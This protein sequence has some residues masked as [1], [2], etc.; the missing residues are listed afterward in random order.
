MASAEPG[1]HLTGEALELAREPRAGAVGLLLP[2]VHG[3]HA[4]GATGVGAVGDAVAPADV[5]AEVDQRVPARVGEASVREV[6]A[7]I[8]PH[9]SMLQLP[10][11]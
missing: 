1:V 7:N 5:S 9:V 8:S 6:G 3:E 11:V 4:I 10:A 2:P